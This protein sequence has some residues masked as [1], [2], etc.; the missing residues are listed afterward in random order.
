MEDLGIV[1][2]G[3]SSK[4]PQTT[5][6]KPKSPRK[7]GGVPGAPKKAESAYDF[8]LKDRQIIHLAQV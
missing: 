6:T 1:V 7:K 2:E 3:S 5:P 4:P 8:F